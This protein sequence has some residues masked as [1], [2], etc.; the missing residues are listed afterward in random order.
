[1]YAA[2]APIPAEPWD[3]LTA[4]RRI[5]D[6]APTPAGA[7]RRE[8][9]CDACATMHASRAPMRET[10]PAD[11]PTRQRAYPPTHRP[12]TESRSISPPP[13][14]RPRNRPRHPRAQIV[15]LTNPI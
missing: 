3:A 2:L 14:R 9:L 10:S 11:A 1:M 5:V 4:E 7:A 13:F 8:P 12:P 6:R 15:A